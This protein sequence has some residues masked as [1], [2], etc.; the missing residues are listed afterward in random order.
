MNDIIFDLK[1]NITKVKKASLTEMQ[2]KKQPTDF[3]MSENQGKKTPCNLYAI[4][5]R[6]VSK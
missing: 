2:K 3:S 5:Y 6:A 4:F 1:Q